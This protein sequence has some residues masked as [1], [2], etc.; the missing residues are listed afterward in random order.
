MKKLYF[1]WIIVTCLLFW[2]CEDKISVSNLNSIQIIS[3]NDILMPK[4]STYLYARG[5]DKDG[6]RLDKISVSWS[7]SNEDIASIDQ[8]GKVEA[9]SKGIAKITASSSQI[10]ATSDIVVSIN[11]KRVL[12]E[13]FTSST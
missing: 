10:S 9:I 1:K 8:E 12:S 3:S 13:M 5:Y 7:S 6:N 2:A 11:K 4:Q